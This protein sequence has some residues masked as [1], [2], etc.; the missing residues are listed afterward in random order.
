MFPF[1]HKRTSSFFL[2]E[3]KEAIA[4]AITQ[5]EKNTSGEIRVFIENHCRFVDATDRAAELFCQLNMQ[6]TVARNGVLLYL[7]IK[8]RQLAVWG[9]QGIHEKLGTAYWKGQVE[10]ILAAFNQR[11]YSEGICSCINAIGEALQA[12]FPYDADNDQNELDNEVIFA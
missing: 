1:L 6:Q 7:A 12:H 3:E 11:N 2:P 10:K 9:D 5:A 4:A 8:D